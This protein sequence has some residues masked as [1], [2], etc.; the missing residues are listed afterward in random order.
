MDDKMKRLVL[1]GSL[2]GLAA[3]S[4]FLN[5]EPRNEAYYST[6]I[7]D[8]VAH[9]KRNP[10]DKR[11]VGSSWYNRSTSKSFALPKMMNTEMD[12]EV[13]EGAVGATAAG[14][15]RAAVVEE[16]VREIDLGRTIKGDK[17][18]DTQ[19]RQTT[20]EI[21]QKVEQSTIVFIPEIKHSDPNFTGAARNTTADVKITAELRP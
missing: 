13:I 11:Y 4:P 5:S 1:I 9:A 17:L 12:Q 16:P 3:L 18:A 6:E 2:A 21:P 15:E 8:A 20:Q 10:V 14:D 19:Q 7:D